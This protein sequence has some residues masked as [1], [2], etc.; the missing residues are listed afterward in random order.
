MKLEFFLIF[1]FFAG[2]HQ[3]KANREPLSKEMQKPTQD[4]IN[5]VPMDQLQS[6]K[7]HAMLIKSQKMVNTKC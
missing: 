2:G 4:Y 1:W 6:G 3:F 5:L 7:N